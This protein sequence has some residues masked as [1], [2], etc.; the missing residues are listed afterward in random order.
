MIPHDSMSTESVMTERSSVLQYLPNCVQIIT[1]LIQAK[2]PCNI[3][4]GTLI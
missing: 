2:S 4:T 3:G 1:Y